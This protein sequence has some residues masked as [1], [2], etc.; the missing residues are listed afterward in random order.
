MATLTPVHEISGVVPEDT[1]DRLIKVLGV[2]P[3]AGIDATLASGGFDSVKAE[4]KN[5]IREGWSA[6][7]VLEQIHDAIIPLVG[8]PTIPKSQAALAMAECDKGLC[9]GGDEELQLLDCCLL[10]RE[11]M[12]R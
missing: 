10:I 7:Q 5:V 3:S 12:L 8:I 6:G 11:A 1:V 4:V 9:E 2:E